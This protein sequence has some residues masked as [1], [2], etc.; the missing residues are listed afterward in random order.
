M[1]DVVVVSNDNFIL[2]CSYLLFVKP[3]LILYVLCY[4]LMFK[5][6]T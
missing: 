4:A 2:Y 5:L 6:L 3:L 1:L